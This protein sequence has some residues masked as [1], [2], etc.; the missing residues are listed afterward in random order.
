LKLVWMNPQDLELQDE[1][2][3]SH[4]KNRIRS[5]KRVTNIKC[6]REVTIKWFCSWSAVSHPSHHENGVGKTQEDWRVFTTAGERL[7][8]ASNKRNIENIH[9]K[10]TKRNESFKNRLLLCRNFIS[11]LS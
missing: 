6:W 10:P 5:R 8:T 4:P 1:E 3:S 7:P 2:A 9:V 11:F